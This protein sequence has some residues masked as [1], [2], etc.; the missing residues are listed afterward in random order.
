[1]RFASLQHDI[2]WEDPT[3]TRASIEPALDSIDLPH[4]SFLL[5]PELGDT[6]FSF[7][8]D[9]IAELD[10]VAWARELARSRGWHVQ[11]GHAERGPEGL[12]RNR[13]TVVAPDGEILGAYDKIHPFSFAG[14]DRVYRGGDRL[15][16]VEAGGFSI[17]PLVCYDLRFPELWRLATL[18]GAEVFTI[19]ASWP[20]KRS[21]HWRSLLIARAIEN[22]AFV[23]ACNRV[24]RDPKH[25]YGG[26][27]LIVDPTGVVLAEGDAEVACVAADLERH[28]L[29]EWRATFPAIADIRREA[30]GAIAIDRGKGPGRG[31]DNPAESRASSGNARAS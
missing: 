1:M 28:R 11:F 7:D 6:G 31:V 15:L 27:S 20:A 21:S 5:L 23:V 8:L 13:A 25:E 12:G 30:L 10:G 14:E 2:A 9:R 16:I 4:G 24:G 26:G 18:A 19:G 29:V 17:C 22:Q 3:R